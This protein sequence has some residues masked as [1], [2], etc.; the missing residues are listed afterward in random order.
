M[1]SPTWHNVANQSEWQAQHV[2]QEIC[3]G[4][5]GDEKVRRRPHSG[6]AIYHSYH[7]AVAHH[8]DSKDEGIGHTEEN[9]DGKRVSKRVDVVPR[10]IPGVATGTVLLC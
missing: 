1:E 10:M 7:E 5:I 2:N 3:T 4:K 6:A 8:T 9:R